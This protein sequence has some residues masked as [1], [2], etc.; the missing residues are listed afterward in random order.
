MQP[1]LRSYTKSRT[2]KDG[3]QRSVTN[4]QKKITVNEE[5]ESQT[6]NR[7]QTGL[8]LDR[9]RHSNRNAKQN[10]KLWIRS[11]HTSKN[12]ELNRICRQKQKKK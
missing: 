7:I 10:E 3:D 9:R 6:K 2:I 8:K 1:P 11:N 5:T 12:N 4:T